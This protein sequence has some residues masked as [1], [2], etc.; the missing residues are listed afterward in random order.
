MLFFVKV[1]S[2]LHSFSVPVCDSMNGYIQN[3]TDAWTMITENVLVQIQLSVG[4]FKNSKDTIFFSF[5]SF[6]FY[7]ASQDVF[8]GSDLS[9]TDTL[10]N[11]L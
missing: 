6:F 7:F 3:M 2:A 8:S 9:I 10:D 11:S 4:I 1:F 5:F